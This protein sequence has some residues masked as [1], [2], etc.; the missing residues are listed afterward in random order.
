MGEG[1]EQPLVWSAAL[2]RVTLSA[3]PQARVE[4]SLLH[5]AQCVRAE[6][7]DTVTKPVSPLE[8][9]KKGST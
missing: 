4:A 1:P 5:P 9:P 6:P 8:P 7:C 3:E 2:G